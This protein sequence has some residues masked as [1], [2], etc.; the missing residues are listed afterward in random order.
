MATT[1]D[2]D[3]WVRVVDALGVTRI[4]AGAATVINL[5]L[6]HMTETGDITDRNRWQGL[7]YLA[8]DYLAGPS[9]SLEARLELVRKVVNGFRRSRT[10]DE[11]R[12]IH[13]PPPS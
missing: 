10:A 6:D 1:K 2:S 7:E 8:A 4:P 11:R 13:P 5:A 12:R 3:A 9:N